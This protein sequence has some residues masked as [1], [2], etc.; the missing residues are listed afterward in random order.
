MT[1]VEFSAAIDKIIKD[2]KLTVGQAASGLAGIIVAICEAAGEDPVDFIMW[3]TQ[4]SREMRL[5]REQQALLDKAKG[6]N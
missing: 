6:S 4:Q 5:K 2:N 3:A 1:P